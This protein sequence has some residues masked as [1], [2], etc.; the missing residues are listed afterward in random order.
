LL[1]PV[2]SNSEDGICRA[3]GRSSLFLSIR[4]HNIARY[5]FIILTFSGLLSTGWFGIPLAPR[6]FLDSSTDIVAGLFTLFSALGAI[7]GMMA[8]REFTRSIETVMEARMA[9]RKLDPMIGDYEYRSYNPITKNYD[10]GFVPSGPIDFWDKETQVP[11]WMDKGKYWHVLLSLDARTKDVQLRIVKDDELSFKQG[12]RS[13]AITSRERVETQMRGARRHRYVVKV[14]QWLVMNTERKRF[15]EQRQVVDENLSALVSDL[16]RRI[17]EATDEVADWERLRIRYPWKIMNI[18]LY[19]NKSLPLRIVYRQVIRNFPGAKKRV[20]DETNANLANIRDDPLV[21]SMLELASAKGIPPSR[22]EMLKLLI[23]F[24]KNAYT[25]LGLGEG[26]SEYHSFHHS[27][28]VSYMALHMLPREIDDFVFTPKDVELIL[29]AGLL[30]DYDPEQATNASEKNMQKG[31]SVVRTID[32]VERSRIIDAYFTM[33]REEFADYFREYKSA[34]S[35]ATE[36]AT[37]HP[38]YVKIEWS[39]I[40]T[41]MV[42]ALIWRTD[43]PFPKQKLAQDMFAKLLAQ[44]TSRGMDADKVSLM[45]ETLWL[46]DLAVTYMGSDPVRAWERVT[47]LYDELNLPKL[48]A[49]PRTDAFF[50]DF[51][52]NTLFNRLISTKYFPFIFR[53]RWKLIYDFFHEGNPSTQLNR[54]IA[55]A[56]KM[57]AAVNLEIGMRKGEM[58][59]TMAVENWSEYF[60]GIG[61][62]QGEVFESK[63]KFAELDPQNASA[64]WGDTERLLPSIIDRTIDNVFL[65]LPEHAAPVSAEARASFRAMLTVLSRKLVRGG[66]FRILTD[67]EA[68]TPVFDQLIDIVGQ[69]NF[70]RVAIGGR[71]YFPTGWHDPEFKKGRDSQVIAVAPKQ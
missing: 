32:E 70:E 19:L 33:S 64:F 24:L 44:L 12:R 34:F 62:D 29:V 22:I 16:N 17:V 68:G 59:R 23:L 63:S 52:E 66:T 57:Y 60:I 67:I 13:V 53:Q 21:A 51:A 18:G 1:K 49:V 2:P 30:H 42:Q 56:R 45:A 26:A 27:L 9:A 58:L 50:G 3:Y 14:P 15:V 4:H 71:S 47:N 6:Y 65:V 46:A 8:Y 43:F 10:E 61:R 11:S 69:S 5:L 40:D 25:K 54:T 7:W 41:A 39:P 28:E 31:P 20:L 48:E 37:T 35:P 36:F 55:T 38:E